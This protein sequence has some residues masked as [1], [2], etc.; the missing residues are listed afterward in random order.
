MGGTLHDLLRSHWRR[1]VFSVGG[2][3]VLVGAWEERHP[4]QAGTHPFTDL[5]APR[6]RCTSWSWPLGRGMAAASICIISVGRSCN[7]AQPRSF[8]SWIR[9]FLCLAGDRDGEDIKATGCAGTFARH[10]TSLAADGAIACFSSNP[11]PFSLDADRAPQLKASVGC[12]VKDSNMTPIRRSIMMGCLVVFSIC[13]THVLTPG[14]ARNQ[15]T[16]KKDISTLERIPDPKA[17]EIRR[18]RTAEDWPN[19]IVIVNSDSF[20]LISHVDGR[21]VQE[22]LNLADL[23]KTLTKLQLDRW[24][25]GRVVA[26]QENGLRSPGDNEKI[27]EKSKEVKHMLEFHKVMIELWPS[28]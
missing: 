28:G 11:V 17:E 23:E 14:T 4:I 13:S 15:K 18:I 6:V 7:A 21:R 22:G 12:L 9:L 8:H 10:P 1:T 20:Y 2:S 25:L 16:S 19:P 27:S 3:L 26:V 5:H 24:P